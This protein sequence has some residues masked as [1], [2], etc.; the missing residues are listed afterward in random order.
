[1]DCQKTTTMFRLL[2]LPQLLV[3]VVGCCQQCRCYPGACVRGVHH[4]N[5]VDD[6][7]DGDDEVRPPPPLSLLRRR[8]QCSS[9]S[10]ATQNEAMDLATAEP[11]RRLRVR[12][13]PSVCSSTQRTW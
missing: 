8:E 6:D 7:D 11:W 12:G 9:A 4:E 3:H 5:D 13:A 1:M 2:A 10:A